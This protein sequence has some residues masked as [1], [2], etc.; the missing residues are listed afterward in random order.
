MAKS[1]K[2]KPGDTPD[3]AARSGEHDATGAKRPPGA[4]GPPRP[5]IG[6]SRGAITLSREELLAPIGADWEVDADL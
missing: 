1:R 5:F 3:S 4:A 2:G 6:R